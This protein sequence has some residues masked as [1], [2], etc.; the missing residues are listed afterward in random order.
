M[1]IRGEGPLVQ[2]SP[3]FFWSVEILSNIKM[4]PNSALKI[5]RLPV[6]EKYIFFS[7]EN[8]ATKKCV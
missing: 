4:W 6:S 3:N 2:W 1:D 7:N 8:A 5:F